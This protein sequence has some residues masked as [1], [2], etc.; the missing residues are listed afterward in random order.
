MFCIESC[1]S[2]TLGDQD[3]AN[4]VAY[5]SHSDTKSKSIRDLRSDGPTSHDGLHMSNSTPAG[6]HLETGD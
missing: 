6:L 1:A 4:T 5:R 2:K 3:F